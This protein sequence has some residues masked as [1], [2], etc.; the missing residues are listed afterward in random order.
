MAAP[1]LCR[2]CVLPAAAWDGSP[3]VMRGDAVIVEPRPLPHL[4]RLL[5]NAWESL[6]RGM[7]TIHLLHNGSEPDTSRSPTLRAALASGGLRFRSIHTISGKPDHGRQWYN[8]LLLTHA[9]WSSFDAP[10]LLL[11]ESD[12]VFCEG[13]PASC[14]VFTAISR[15]HLGRLTCVLMFRPA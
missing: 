10:H 2:T 13:E 9:F 8:A 6:P 4:G 1:D 12:S 3:R 11:F 5:L 15:S 7:W 14:Y